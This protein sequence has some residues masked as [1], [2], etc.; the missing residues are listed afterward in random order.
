MIVAAENVVTSATSGPTD[1][2]LIFVVLSATSGL[3]GIVF[4]T[5]TSVRP[6][7]HDPNRSKDPTLM[8]EVAVGA[9][10]VRG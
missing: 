7:T 10:I 2:T 1:R 8:H 9:T 3:S 5:I 4:A 6:C